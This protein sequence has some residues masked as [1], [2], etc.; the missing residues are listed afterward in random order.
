MRTFAPMLIAFAVAAVL[1]LMLLPVGAGYVA[2]TPTAPG[3]ADLHITLGDIPD[4]FGAGQT[5]EFA[6]ELR[7]AGQAD[8][9]ALVSWVLSRDRTVDEADLILPGP[10]TDG[11]V[12]RAEEARREYVRYP[13][14]EGLSGP[15][16]LIARADPMV[17]D[18]RGQQEP[19]VASRSIWIENGRSAPIVVDAIDA[20]PS[21]VAGGSLMVGHTLRN[22]GEGWAPGPWTDEVWLS[23]DSTVSDDD[24]LL[25][26]VPRRRPLAP[27]EAARIPAGEVALPFNLT[28]GPY[29]LIVRPGTET[30][31]T[32]DVPL[33]LRPPT[34]PDLVVRQVKLPSR[35]VLGRVAPLR[36]DVVNRSPVDADAAAAATRTDAVFLSADDRLSDDDVLLD[37]FPGSAALPGNHR[38]R[39]GP[40]PLRVSA[41]QA[42]S[43]AMF[44]LVVADDTNTVDEG[45]QEGNNVAAVAVDLIDPSDIETPDEI[46]LGRENE[47]PRVTVAWIAYDAFEAL[48][49]RASRTEQP[50]VQDRADPVP[51]APLERDPED[52]AASVARPPVPPSPVIGTGTAPPSARVADRSRQPF[53]GQTQGE[54]PTGEPAPVDQPGDAAVDTPGLPVPSPATDPPPPP[55]PPSVAAERE[56][57]KPTS[58]PRDDRE[59]DP[60]RVVDAGAVRPGAVLVGPGLEI[61]TFR[62]RRSAVGGTTVPRNPTALITFDTDGVVIDAELSPGTGFENVDAPILESLY[63]WKAEGERIEQR[64]SPLRI[65][66]QILLNDAPLA[67]R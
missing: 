55:Q 24:V 58:A 8:G 42:V 6:V 26:R 14:P 29:R 2:R 9:S 54:L 34:H 57:E 7:N 3:R 32:L 11:V 41:E 31:R 44:V 63:R 59:A 37:A 46:E 45:G 35:I 64:T 33:N 48:Q 27:G 12:L 39:R 5:L 66:I 65:Q 10:W 67:P 23:V 1:H 21:A 60:T 20:P 61:R 62:P 43:S 53:E 47:V 30:H 17:P 19:A 49:A 52:A 38:L 56:G 28:P 13:L 36:F 22:A 40:L 16:F 51:D 18:A 25:R 50:I 15:Y 4:T